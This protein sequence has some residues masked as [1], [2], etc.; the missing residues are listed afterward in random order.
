MNTQTLEKRPASD[1]SPVEQTRS[2]GVYLPPVDIYETRDE[3]ALVAD[4]PGVKGD[5]VH[6]QFE[7]GELSIFAR[8][9]GRQP[10]GTRYLLSEYEAGDFFRSFRISEEIDSSRIT[11]EY[12][13]GVLI[14]HLPKVEQAKPR[15]I[16]V[17]TSS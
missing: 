14:L 13:D 5:E 11:A 4:L 8:A 2:G 16:A 10:E 3:L 6:I 1:R 12:R 7:K 17:K 9:E 15:R